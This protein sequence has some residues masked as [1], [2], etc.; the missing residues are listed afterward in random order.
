MNKYNLKVNT[1]SEIEQKKVLNDSVFPRG[2]VIPNNERFVCT[3]NFNMR[4][5]LWT[6]FYI[7]KT[8]LLL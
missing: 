1:M 5:S 2:S 7:K 3:E 8:Y 6:C 4:A